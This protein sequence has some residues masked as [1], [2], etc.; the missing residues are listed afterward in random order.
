VHMFY[1]LFT[2][3]AHCLFSLPRL[4]A[5]R[6]DLSRNNIAKAR[7][8]LDSVG[9]L[10]ETTTEEIPSLKAPEQQFLTDARRAT[11]DEPVRADPGS[12]DSC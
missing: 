4:T 10:F 5:R 7:A 11:T 6:V 2:T 8:G 12:W 3:V 1:S 9:V